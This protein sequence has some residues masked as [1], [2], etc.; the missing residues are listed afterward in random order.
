MVITVDVVPG[1]VEIT[2][3]TDDAGSVTGSLSQNAVNDDT[4]PQN[5]G[6]AKAGSTVT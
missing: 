6:T 1:K 4:R 3:V 5:S 2:G